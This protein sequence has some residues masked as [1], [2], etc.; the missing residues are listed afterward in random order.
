[1]GSVH[2]NSTKNSIEFDDLSFEYSGSSEE[3][4]INISQKKS[5]IDEA[6]KMVDRRDIYG[7]VEKKLIEL[8]K[9]DIWGIEHDSV[10]QCVQF[11]KNYAKVYGFVARYDEKGYDFNS[12]LNMRQMV[13]NREGTLRKKYLK[14][15]NRKRY[16]RPITR[17]ICQARIRFH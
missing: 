16:H 17:V 7:K 13:C 9:D 4:D 10:E 1:M 15:E 11:Y 14:M 2:K 8:T 5:T 12:N 6:M 3:N